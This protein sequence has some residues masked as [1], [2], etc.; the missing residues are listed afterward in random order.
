VT[1]ALDR[2]CMLYTSQIPAIESPAW[3]DVPGSGEEPET[4]ITPACIEAYLFAVCFVA[5]GFR[6][7]INDYLAD[8]AKSRR[9]F[10][11]FDTIVLMS[12]T[13][14]LQRSCPIM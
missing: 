14:P 2:S 3:H 4:Y 1:A 12:Y 8:S 13:A 5:P 7:A 11:W 9:W 10:L 6:R